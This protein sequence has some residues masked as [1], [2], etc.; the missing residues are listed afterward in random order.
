MNTLKF[1]AGACLIAAIAGCA[2][3]NGS[4]PGANNTSAVIQCGAMTAG[5]ALVGGILGGK[6]G[7]MRGAI[8]GLAACAVVEIAT[9]QT[10]SAAEVEQKYRTANR[11]AL[12]PNAKLLAYSTTVSP[13]GMAK[14]GDAIKVQSTIRAVSGTNEPVREIKEVL[15]AYA[16]NGEEFKRGEKVVNINAG[17]GEFDNSFTLR[18][19]QGSPEGVYKLRTQIIL[20]GKQV[21][22]NEG[23]LQ[24]AEAGVP[25]TSKLAAAAIST[26]VQ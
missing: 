21:S 5:G 16:P 2:T 17:S 25:R 22:S 15:I 9:R 8:A 3:P 1:A 13:Q 12:P 20:N 10:S 19:P 24:I 18:L 7:A 23:S 6:T 11:N 14:V 4:T 26:R